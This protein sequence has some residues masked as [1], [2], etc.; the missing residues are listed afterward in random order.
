[1]AGTVHALP[2]TVRLATTAA[3][4]T[5]L[6]V[7]GTGYAVPA[8]QAALPVATS[9]G[10]VSAV[11]A[12]AVDGS[13]ETRYA[14][15]TPDGSIP[16]DVVAPPGSTLT[17]AG[18]P[19]RVS[20]GNILAAALPTLGTPPARGAQV[21]HTVNIA[22]AIPSDVTMTSAATAAMS[23]TLV[24]MV[25]Y[26]V[27]PYWAAVTGDRIDVEAG[28][29]V[30]YRSVFTRAQFCSLGVD[31]FTTEAARH[32]LPPVSPRVHTMVAAAITQCAVFA[33]LA[34]LGSDGLGSSTGGI[35][36]AA[37]Y[38]LYAT[39]IAHELGHNLGLMHANVAT[40]YASPRVADGPG[41]DCRVEEYADL[42][43]VMGDRYAT[44]MD[45]GGP[46][47]PVHMAVLGI[48]ADLRPVT[49]S[50]DGSSA[51]LSPLGGQSGA[52]A[53]VVTA[54]NGDEYY[55][56]LRTPVGL[57]ATV[58]SSRTQLGATAAGVYLVK[59]TSTRGLTYS[60]MRRYPW[61]ASNLL[62]SSGGGAASAVTGSRLTLTP[63]VPVPLA[64]GL[65]SVT[66]TRLTS[67]SATVVLHT[68]TQ[69]GPDPVLVASTPVPVRG[70]IARVTGKAVSVPVTQGWVAHLDP[71]SPLVTL[72]VSGVSVAPTVRSTTMT[73]P[74]VLSGRSTP[75]G[76][77]V[78][79]V[80][81]S[82]RRMA[83]VTGT[84]H[85]LYLDD[86]ARTNVRYTSGWA[87]RASSGALGGAATS[88]AKVGSRASVTVAGRSFGVL[89]DTGPTGGRF[90][91]LLDGKPVASGT[92]YA[93]SSH[94]GVTAA[95]VRAGTPGAHTISVQVVSGRIAFDGLVAVS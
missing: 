55:L 3:L 66:L 2:R 25:T 56:E 86:T 89:L 63:G 34:T 68:R 45:P 29:V 10:V 6:A 84:V 46:L 24:R 70:S 18:N 93:R 31:P 47:T 80:D 4:A 58:I 49:L 37:G 81:A 82:H 67:A 40:C 5:A 75:H 73:L 11:I 50:A 88:S 78:T 95:T 74:T 57:D 7:T 43:D 65:A 94:R 72:A 21:L 92:S 83:T 16:M 14:L 54:A 13:S 90:V 77:S 33:G 51:V 69:V 38:Q 17:V 30:T 28:A 91:V 20:A 22:V 39:V 36:L 32:G 62:V 23:A 44:V 19:A 53:A 1:M 60:D 9:T 26:S 64:D 42:S 35:V 79:G 85:E 15:D 8:G 48:L 61:G 12:D 27:S 71:Y 41:S 76:W 52:R 59:R 87:R